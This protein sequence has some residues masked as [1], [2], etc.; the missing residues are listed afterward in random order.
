MLI[1]RNNGLRHMTDHVAVW[2]VLPQDI[3]AATNQLCAS[4][5]Q[6]VYRITLDT[7]HLLTAF[8]IHACRC[9]RA[10]R[11]HS[12][13][14]GASEAAGSSVPSSNCCRTCADAAHAVRLNRRPNKGA[15]VSTHTSCYRAC[16][17]PATAACGWSRSECHGALSTRKRCYE[18]GG[19]LMGKEGRA[20]SVLADTASPGT[21]S[22]LG[23]GE[24]TL[25]PAVSMPPTR[26]G[27]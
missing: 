22:P 10:R 8:H 12:L 16:R 23:E 5:F 14:S 26:R 1:S 15:R 21:L 4:V 3:D 18:S 13:A 2:C 27:V 6:R 9:S 7:H 24:T 19:R 11:L 20:G 17:T 25:R